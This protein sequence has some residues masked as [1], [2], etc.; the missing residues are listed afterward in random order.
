[1]DVELLFDATELDTGDYYASITVHSND[2]VTPSVV[3]PVHMIV[4]TTVGV[5]D[6]LFTPLVFNLEQNYPNPFNPSTMIKYSIPELSKV[7]LTL[8]NL[9]GE[10][11][12][13][14][15]NEEKIAGNYSVEF[16]A[17][18]LPSGVYFYQLKAGSY[19]ETKKMLL[20]K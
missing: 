15:V 7:R 3:V 5:E 11:V 13:T 20:L 14:L 17:T 8:F 6:E 2:P 4:S 1:M 16:N 10:E 19:I 9:L 18:S 12:T